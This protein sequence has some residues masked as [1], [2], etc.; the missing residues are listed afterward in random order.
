M[1]AQQNQ[2]KA[3]YPPKTMLEAIEL[4][5]AEGSFTSGEAN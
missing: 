5:E 1:K 4:L 2:P 3:T